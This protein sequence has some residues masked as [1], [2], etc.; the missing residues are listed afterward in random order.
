MSTNTTGGAR[1]VHPVMFTKSGDRPVSKDLRA[2]PVPAATPEV[3]L[4]DAV[5]DLVETIADLAVTDLEAALEAALD[6]IPAAEPS[7]D[8]NETAKPADGAVTDAELLRLLDFD[9]KVSETEGGPCEA[10]RVTFYELLLE[11]DL[12]EADARAEAWPEGGVQRLIDGL[13]EIAE[14][15]DE[16]KPTKKAK[17]G[18]APD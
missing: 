10:D 6:E 8:D 11:R 13:T 3:A 7:T 5:V 16:P 14:A 12:S 2:R 4:A 15:V 1:E 17:Q 18:P 9:Y